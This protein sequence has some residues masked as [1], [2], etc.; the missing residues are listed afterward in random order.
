MCRDLFVLVEG[1][2][3]F[4]DSVLFGPLGPDLCDAER[5][6]SL[7]CPEGS[8]SAGSGLSSKETRL[9]SAADFLDDSFES[10]CGLCDS[11]SDVPGWV[12]SDTALLLLPVGLR[13][14][15]SW[16]G[17]LDDEP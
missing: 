12:F 8:G 9:S 1:F 16:T 14:T 5:W 13:D 6:A 4:I 10:S 15:R 3:L 7:F 11:V 17:T 2:A